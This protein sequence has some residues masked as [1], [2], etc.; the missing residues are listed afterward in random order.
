MFFV[1]KCL[2]TNSICL[3]LIDLSNVSGFFLESILVVCVFQ[4]AETV[5]LLDFQYL[6]FNLTVEVKGDKD[7]ISSVKALK[8]LNKFF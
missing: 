8:G 3:H 5:E 6:I 1:G 4:G 2:I 7:M